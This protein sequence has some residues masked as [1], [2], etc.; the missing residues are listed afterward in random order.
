MSFQETRRCGVDR[1][2]AG[3]DEKDAGSDPDFAIDNI[4]AKP[5]GYFSLSRFPN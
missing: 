3:K 4:S 1:Y 5:D 2:A